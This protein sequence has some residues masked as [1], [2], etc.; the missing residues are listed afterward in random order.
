MNFP[1]DKELANSTL[2]ALE[3]RGGSATIQ[4]LSH[5][6]A[7]I[8]GLSEA[9]LR[10]PLNAPSHAGRGGFVRSSRFNFRSAWA[11]R[12]LRE[13]GAIASLRRGTWAI[14]E[15]GRTLLSPASQ[16]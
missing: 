15:Y 8:L 4:D 14:T 10:E 7:A 2:Q 9:V 13:K 12:N 5:D 3:Q 6:M 16:S 1:T 11:R